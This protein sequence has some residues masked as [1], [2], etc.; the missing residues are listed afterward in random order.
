VSTN[1]LAICRVGNALQLKRVKT[2]NPVQTLLEGI[3]ATQEQQF[4]QGI[5]TEIP[6][7]GGWKPDRHEMLVADVDDEMT[8]VWNAALQNITALPELASNQFQSEGIKALCVVA[9]AA[10]NRRL[11]IQNFSARQILDRSVAFVLDGD[12]F[13]K[14]TEPAFTLGTG[15]TAILNGQALKFKS[16]TGA[17]MIFDLK[18]LYAEATDAQ[19]DAFAQH[20]MLNVADVV[21]LKGFADQGIRKLVHAISEK[22]VLDQYTLN[23]IS[24]AA[25]AQNFPLTVQNNRLILPTNRGDVKKLLHFLDEGF[26]RGAMSG[27]SY[28]TNSKRQ[29][30]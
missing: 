10:G 21:A 22:G 14:L 23:G 28:I 30:N 9:G 16:F 27:V 4:N 19:I 17:R 29:I 13:R 20:P 11:L 2:T 1:L 15:I 12:T 25:A 24:V 6:F 5:T 8:A 7:D 3:F 26:Y 18:S